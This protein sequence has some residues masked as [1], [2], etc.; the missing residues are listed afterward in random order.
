LRGIP[1][2]RHTLRYFANTH[3]YLFHNHKQAGETRNNHIYVDINGN[4]LLLQGLSVY[5]YGEKTI[6]QSVMDRNT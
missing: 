5:S 2:N 1:F 3:D 6:A 4:Q